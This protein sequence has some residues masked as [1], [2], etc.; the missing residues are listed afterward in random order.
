MI[1]ILPSLIIAPLYFAKQVELGTITQSFGAFNHILGD[2][3]ILINQFE[4]LSAF[5]AGLSRLSTFVDSLDSSNITVTSLDGSVTDGKGYPMIAMTSG[6]QV[7]VDLK[8]SVLSVRNLSIL[9]PDG[10]RV[11][12]GS[13][14]ENNNEDVL[15]TNI[16]SNTLKGIDVDI[17]EGDQI[18]VVGRSGV[19]KSSFVRAIAGLWRIGSGEVLWVNN[20]VSDTHLI[21]TAPKNVFFLPQKPYNNLGTL[22]EQIMYP[23]INNFNETLGTNHADNTMENVSILTS[24]FNSSVALDNHLLHLLSLVKLENLSNRMGFGN[25]MAGLN[26]VNDWSKV[27]SLGEQQRLA[28]ARVLFNKPSVV[29]LD[30]KYELLKVVFNFLMTH[31]YIICIQLITEATSALDLENEKAM[32]TALMD[33]NVTYVSVGHRPSLL[34]YH[35]K[36]LVL[37]GVGGAVDI[38][39]INQANAKTEN[40]IETDELLVN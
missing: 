21:T 37:G 24:G 29:F 10:R 4:S 33:L 7:S 18:L 22:R 31:L 5:S 40:F 16:K 20:S 15:G 23:A 9:T 30:G 17:V 11:I 32:Y 3:S 12:V 39:S 27:L 2:F 35:S 1:Q 19:G 26:V 34:Q 38:I 14:L 28:F 25:E 13:G 6:R 8:K 36:K